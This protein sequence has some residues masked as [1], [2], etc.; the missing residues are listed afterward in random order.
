[1]QRDKKN[2]PLSL[3]SLSERGKATPTVS[4]ARQKILA[5][6]KLDQSVGLASSDG[7]FENKDSAHSG[8]TLATGFV[9]NVVSSAISK[10][11]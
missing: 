3:H 6:R 7:S 5:A 1:M 8:N 11:T 2:F 9:L 4:S 10:I